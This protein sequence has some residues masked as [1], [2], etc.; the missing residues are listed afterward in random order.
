MISGHS[1]RSNTL[2]EKVNVQYGLCSDLLTCLLH[3][4]CSP[5][6]LLPRSGESSPLDYGVSRASPFLWAYGVRCEGKRGVPVVP[7]AERLHLRCYIC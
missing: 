4:F 6:L 2:F 1:H 3:R 7:F 5:R